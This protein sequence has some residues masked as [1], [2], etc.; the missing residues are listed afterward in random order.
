[1]SACIY[2]RVNPLKLEAR[3]SW[4][5]EERKLC[6]E[7]K[8]KSEA[9]DVLEEWWKGREKSLMSAYRILPFLSPFIWYI[10]HEFSEMSFAITKDFPF[11]DHSKSS[12]SLLAVTLF[13]AFSFSFEKENFR[14]TKLLVSLK[15]HF[16]PWMYYI[17]IWII[18]L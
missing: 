14:I 18:V 9:R 10:L 7:G 16:V 5:V 6:G 12:L 2:G 11:V 17:L 13:V 1:M 3:K 4:R 15:T 8:K